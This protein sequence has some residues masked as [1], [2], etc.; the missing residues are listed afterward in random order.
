M[1]AF[2]GDGIMSAMKISMI[3]EACKH[4]EELIK[5]CAA[6]LEIRELPAEA[7][8]SAEYDP[9]I[10]GS[11]VVITLKYRRPAGEG[12]DFRV[13]QV[14][15]AGLDGIETNSLPA[16]ALLCNVYEHQIPIAEYVM[17]AMLECELRFSEMRR[18]F[19][20]RRWASLYYSRVPHGELYTK[21]LALIGFGGIAR[22]IA[23][24]ARAFGMRITAVDKYAKDPDGLADLLTDNGGMDRVLKEADY[25]VLAETEGMINAERLAVM[26]DSAVL[27][28]VS[29]GPLI[30]EA[31][32]YEALKE[33]RLGG[34]VLDVWWRYPRNRDDETSPADFPFESLDNVICTPHSSAWTRE[35]MWRRYGVIAKNIEN[36]SAGRPLR[37][38]IDYKG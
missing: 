1:T 19:D 15:G 26:K 27:I 22:E 3:G 14:P 28:N 29:R 11:D 4:K 9:Q 18:R 25:L 6:E 12:P 32:L 17:T 7:A 34:A 33:K 10:A 2:N 20:P 30:V 16:G 5:Q 24:R 37:N 13:L 23:K 31:D 36:L 35:L 38:S 8:Y 21:T